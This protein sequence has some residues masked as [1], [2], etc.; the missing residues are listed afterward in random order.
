MP[1]VSAPITI[2]QFQSI[3]VSSTQ[4]LVEDATGPRMSISW[5]QD[6]CR[7]THGGSVRAPAGRQGKGSR[8]IVGR[9]TTWPISFRRRFTPSCVPR[10]VQDRFAARKPSEGG[11][12]PAGELIDPTQRRPLGGDQPLHAHDL[13]V[14]GD[15]PSGRVKGSSR[16]Y[17]LHLWSHV[18]SSPAIG[19]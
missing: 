11:E 7:K 16:F 19:L 9:S 15:R 18:L 2:I 8:A 10:G 1:R 14:R 5:E 6:G 17:A 3:A 4:R 13:L 12:F